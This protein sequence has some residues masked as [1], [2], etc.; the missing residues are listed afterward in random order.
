MRCHNVKFFNSK[1][2]KFFN[3]HC[4]SNQSYQT[5]YAVNYDNAT[6]NNNYNNETNDDSIGY[7]DKQSSIDPACR[8]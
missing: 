5:Y 6:N 1:N 2:V 8:Q 3:S 7:D 4:S